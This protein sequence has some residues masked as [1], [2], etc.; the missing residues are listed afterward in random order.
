MIQT[1]T[2]IESSG[3]V[4]GMEA[5]HFVPILGALIF[6]I[7]CFFILSMSPEIKDVPMLV[8]ILIGFSPLVLSVVYVLLF[9]V[10]R[11]PHFQEDFFEN[12]F[13]GSH[14]NGA[15]TRRVQN[16]FINSGYNKS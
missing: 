1:H 8:K 3:K 11:P 16:P 14:F 7:S 6:S 4:C 9:L 10:G 2:D 13:N 15:R 12:G 5:G